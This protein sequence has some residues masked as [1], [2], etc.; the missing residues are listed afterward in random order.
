M[1]SDLQKAYMII[2]FQTGYSIVGIWMILLISS[3]IGL[4]LGTNRTKDSL[5]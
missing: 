3:V 4:G 5:C 2:A 1:D